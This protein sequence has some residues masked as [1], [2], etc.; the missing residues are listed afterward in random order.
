[1][2]IWV[3][4]SHTVAMNVRRL[5]S[6]NVRTHFCGAHSWEWNCWVHRLHM[7]SALRDATK[8]LS[9]LVVRRSTPSRNGREAV[10]FTINMTD[11]PLDPCWGLFCSRLRPGT[12]NCSFLALVPSWKTFS[13]RSDPRCHHAVYQTFRGQ[14]GLLCLIF[15]IVICW[16]LI[17]QE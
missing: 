17:S 6:A 15:H 3:V 12:Q 8:F 7:Y 11:Y 10:V 16:D 9:Q 4:A 13:P 5:L 14:A 1:M 2:G